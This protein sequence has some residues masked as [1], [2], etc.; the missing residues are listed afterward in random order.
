MVNYDLPQDAEDYVHRIGRTARAGAS[1]TAVSFGCEQYVMSLPD[2]EDYIGFRIPVA[3]FDH[4]ALPEIVHPP[5]R[6]R[7][8]RG[9]GRGGDRRGGGGRPPR[10][11]ASGGRPDGDKPA[12]RKRRRRRKPAGDQPATTS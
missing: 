12:K 5:R 8:P 2:I 3:S 4:E 7:K 6:P 9:G 11:S 1:G 10:Q